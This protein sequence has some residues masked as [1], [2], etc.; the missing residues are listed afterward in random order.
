[1]NEEIINYIKSQRVCVLAVEMLD[2][3]P[4]AST[5]HFVETEDPM[6]FLFE[7]YRDYRKCEPLFGREMSRASIVIGC[8]EDTMKTLQLDGEVSL[9]KKE[10]N[11]IYDLYFTKFPNKK[12]K[13]EKMGDKFVLFTFK[14][15]WWRFT[16]WTKPE[17]KLIITSE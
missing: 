12:E 11:K 16:D 7:T 17:G 15:K 2:G 9:V 3:S 4:H 1:M 14:A 10:D 6:V 5:V 8:D 13:S